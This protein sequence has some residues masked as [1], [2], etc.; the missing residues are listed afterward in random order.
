VNLNERQVT[1]PGMIW[2][3][4]RRDVTIFLQSCVVPRLCTASTSRSVRLVLR[5]NGRRRYHADGATRP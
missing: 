1:P 4:T 5:K 2:R 3:A